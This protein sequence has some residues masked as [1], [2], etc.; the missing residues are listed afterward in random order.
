MDE[1]GD[2]PQSRLAID[3]FSQSFSEEL[4]LD[5]TPFH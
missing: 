1:T 5:M 3:I 4:S 2:L